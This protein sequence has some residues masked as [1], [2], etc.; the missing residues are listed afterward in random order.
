MA[1]ESHIARLREGVAAWNE[2]RRTHPEVIPDLSAGVLRGLDLSTA[3]LSDSDLRGADL[4]G[5]QLQRAKLVRARMNQANLF[6]AVLDGADLEDAVL[7]G[8]QFLNCAQLVAASNWSSAH[9]DPSL[10]CGAAI[11]ANG[12]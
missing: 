8:A 11:P 6:K 4:R 7:I 10:G 1:D 2:W 9:R 5:V 3:D 12:Q